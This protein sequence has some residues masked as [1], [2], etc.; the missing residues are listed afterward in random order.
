MKISN[1]VKFFASQNSDELF[2]SILMARGDVVQQYSE[3]G[4]ENQANWHDTL[5]EFDKWTK[6][7][8]DGGKTFPLKFLKNFDDEVVISDENGELFNWPTTITD[9]NNNNA[10]F[11]SN[12]IVLSGANAIPILNEIVNEDDSVSKDS[13]EINGETITKLDFT[14]TK[15]V[16]G[17]SL[18]RQEDDEFSFIE[19]TD[20]S[21]NF[22]QDGNENIRLTC[23]FSVKEAGLTNRKYFYKIK[24]N[25]TNNFF[26]GVKCPV[27]SNMITAIPT[28]A[29]DDF[30]ICNQLDKNNEN[31]KTIIFTY[32]PK[33]IKSI[34]LYVGS[35]EI[36]RSGNVNFLVKIGETEY[37]FV[38]NVTREFSWITFNNYNNA[39][40]EVSITRLTT[41]NDTLNAVC[42]IS[43][44]R[45][46]TE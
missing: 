28:V 16:K 14:K 35:G 32:S 17:V 8:F 34:S 46:E 2:R 31:L 19:I 12:T 33:N 3:T 18:I 26:A 25:K 11:F 1:P 45:V 21:Y 37:E 36:L 10:T 39:Q 4:D 27:Y 41:N 5:S 9:P 44:I 38:R 43:G 42:I 22:S 24:L 23:K 6:I 13:I 29:T 15:Y 40:G 30:G 20:L 7:S